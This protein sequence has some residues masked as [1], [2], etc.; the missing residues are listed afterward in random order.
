MRHAP[1]YDAG[2]FFGLLGLIPGLTLLIVYFET[3]LFRGLREHVGLIERHA[4]L[5]ELD[6]SEERFST[7]IA[8]SI[9]RLLIIQF[10]LVLVGIA[11]LPL[12]TGANLL[13][14][15]QVPIAQIVA[16]GTVMHLALL[17]C[18]LVLVYLDAG[19]Q[20]ALV[21]VVFF[22]STLVATLVLLPFGERLFGVGY[23]LGA[24]VGAVFAALLTAR[25]LRR[26]NGFLFTEA[27]RNS[28]PA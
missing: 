4:T 11:V 17:A 8:G 14:F 7:H 23:L 24:S 5:K 16:L 18:G 19:R 12:A 6:Q 3:A 22:G 1:L 20:F 10:L 15:R 27:A 9:A 13:Q 25:L 21:Q 26:L 28:G 2:L